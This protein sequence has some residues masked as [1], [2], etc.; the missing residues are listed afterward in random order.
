MYSDIPT[1]HERLGSL[2][3][4]LRDQGHLGLILIDASELAQVE[5]D[6]GSKAFHQ[7]LS[8]VS[9]L[10]GEMQGKEVRT[11]DLL[12]LN[13]RGGNAFLLFL[14]PKRGEHERNPRIAAL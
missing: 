14:S 7:V 3:E 6:Y 4:Q 8:M 12:A 1:Y 13:D 11:A 10:V 9:A 2:I 5:H